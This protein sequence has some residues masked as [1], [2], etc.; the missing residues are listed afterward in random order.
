VRSDLA[1]AERAGSGGKHCS[2]R[3]R[4]DKNSR[5]LM[6]D[7]TCGF[8]SDPPLPSGKQSQSGRC[9][10]HCGTCHRAKLATVRCGANSAVRARWRRRR[11]RSRAE[12]VPRSA[13]CRRNAALR[14]RGAAASGPRRFRR[15]PGET[16]RLR[17]PELSAAPR[18]QFVEPT[19][20]ILL[21]N[22]CLRMR[23]PHA[24]IDPHRC[25]GADQQVHPALRPSKGGLSLRIYPQVCLRC[26]LPRMLDRHDQRCRVSMGFSLRNITRPS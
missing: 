7:N 8:A 25:T 10:D 21:D 17:F 24:A 23:D 12:D 19:S 15:P 2:S 14:R 9:I 13:S 16:T 6:T 18:L 4:G 3:V 22:H 11:L 26:W 20:V 5:S 1:S